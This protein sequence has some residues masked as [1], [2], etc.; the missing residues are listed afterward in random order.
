MGIEKSRAAFASLRPR[1]YKR[2]EIV[3]VKGER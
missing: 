3:R 2:D 1:E